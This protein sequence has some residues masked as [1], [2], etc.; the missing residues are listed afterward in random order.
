MI[1]VDVSCSPIGFVRSSQPFSWQSPEWHRLDMKIFQPHRHEKLNEKCQVSKRVFHFDI[2]V[3]ILLFSSRTRCSGFVFTRNKQME[4]EEKQYDWVILF[5]GKKFFSCR[6]RIRSGKK[7]K[8]NLHR[9]DEREGRRALLNI[10]EKTCCINDFPRLSSHRCCFLIYYFC[11]SAKGSTNNSE[12][13]QCRV[14]RAKLCLRDLLR[15]WA[16]AGCSIRKFACLLVD[17]ANLITAVYY[18]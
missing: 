2:R 4:E 11:Q 18:F 3:E 10:I 7:A 17:Y 9:W 5:R 14:A 16:L 13:R 8:G 6:L 12:L 1:V 15:W